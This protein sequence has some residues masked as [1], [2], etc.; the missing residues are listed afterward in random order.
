MGAATAY[1]PLHIISRVTGPQDSYR[2]EL[3]GLVMVAKWAPQ[4][5]SLK[6]WWTL[7]H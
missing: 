2:V 6:R 5:D 4:G 1:G 7:G 3:Q